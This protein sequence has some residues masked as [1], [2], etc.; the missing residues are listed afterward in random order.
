M[1]SGRISEHEEGELEGP[2]HDTLGHDVGLESKDDSVEHT[3]TA[4]P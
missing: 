2:W 1:Y 4:G 3:T